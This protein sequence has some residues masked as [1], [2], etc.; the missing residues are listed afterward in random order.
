MTM[1]HDGDHWAICGAVQDELQ[2]IRG[3]RACAVMIRF[4][5]GTS[6]GVSRPMMSKRFLTM[7]DEGPQIPIALLTCADFGPLSP[8][9]TTAP[10][11]S[12]S[13][14]AQIGRASCRERVSS[15]VV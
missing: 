2:S 12:T 7:G 6:V 11:Q 5:G 8:P 3:Q 1:L 4:C 9:A 14:A 15:Y 13:R 10:A